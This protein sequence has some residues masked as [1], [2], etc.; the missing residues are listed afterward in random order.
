M[1][2]K[3]AAALQSLVRGPVRADER[4]LARYSTDQSI[5]Q[6]RPQVVVYPRD[7]EDVV[8]AVRFARQNGLPI[9]ARGAGSGTAGAAL[10]AGILLAFHAR[11]RDEVPQPMNALLGFESHGD[12]PCATVQPGLLHD[13]LQAYLRQRG[14]YLPADPSSGAFCVLG[15][16]IATKASG[17]HALKHGSIDRYL[18]DLQ[19]VTAEGQVVDMTDPASIPAAIR[20]GLSG[21]SRDLLA[22]TPSV[23]RLAA[24]MDRKLASGYNLFAFLRH[25]ALPDRVAQLLVGSVG[26]LGI[27]TRATLRAEPYQ[28]GRATTLLYFRS[29][30]EAGAAVQQIR[31]LNVAA[32]EIMNHATIAIIARRRGSLD[33]PEGEAHMLLVEYEGQERHDQIAATEALIREHGYRL[34][35]SPATV[36]GAEEQARLW[37]VR[38]AALPTVRNVQ[39]RQA[40][41]VVNDVGVPVPHLA[42]TIREL[43]A[44]FDRLELPAAIYGHA[45]SGNLHLRPL[46]DPHAPDLRAQLACVADEVYALVLRHDG[47]IT[48]EHGMGRLRTPY[49]A[50]E[51]GPQITAYM[52]RVKQAFDPDDTLNPDV[53]FSERALTDNMRSLGG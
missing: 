9:T 15:G 43:E 36:E 27:V 29:L 14:L 33:I 23:Q 17:P 24:R 4:T 49:L 39:G 12:Q 52:R 44:L 28:E 30:A 22:D 19:F 45:G 40:F 47:T 13:D 50:R 25:Q 53:M 51:W 32:I 16:N 18:V 21:L 41:S 31:A 26:T 42:E 1:Q 37:K 35:A 46:F 34:A 3:T 5:Y 20:D 7:L 10:G 48:A 11:P 6:V 38:K 2:S 8:A